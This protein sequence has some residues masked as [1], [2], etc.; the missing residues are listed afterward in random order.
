MQKVKLEISV[1]PN[2]SSPGRLT[3]RAILG[4]LDRA[5]VWAGLFGLIYGLSAGSFLRDGTVFNYHS[6]QAQAW[7]QGHLWLPNVTSDKLDLTPY[8]GHWYSA[9][10]PLPALVMLPFVLVWG[11]EANQVMV[12]VGLGALNVG[13]VHLLVRRL[14]RYW[15]LDSLSRAGLVV[16]YGLGTVVWQSVIQGTVWHLA[17]ACALTL[18]LVALLVGLEGRRLWLV[19]LLVGLAGLARP[20]AWLALLYWLVLICRNYR[21]AAPAKVRIGPVLL[22]LAVNRRAAIPRLL[23]GPLLCFGATLAYN[24]LRFRS[25]TDFGYQNMQVGPNIRADLNNYG[26]FHPHF[27]P[28]NF[29]YAFLNLPGFHARPPFLTFNLDGNSLLLITPAF[30]LVPLAG[31]HLVRAGRGWIYSWPATFTLAAGLASFGTLGAVLL[32][33]N[34]G[35]IQFGYRFL[36]DCLPFALLLVALAWPQSRGWRLV[37]FGLIALS[38]LLNFYGMM[39]YQGWWPQMFGPVNK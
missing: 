39:W 4:W 17:H 15:P 38:V 26:Q 27:L 16:L 22:E 14:S 32:Y 29:F 3:G 37:G 33:F 35:Q 12:G 10:P 30:L 31:R 24:W 28:K 7:L 23:A 5:W 2:S 6:W 21:V 13:L 34:T 18:L 1:R 19:G 25:L 36:Q 11:L 9:F 20:T 8:A